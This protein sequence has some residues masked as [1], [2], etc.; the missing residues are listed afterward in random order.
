MNKA[1]CALILV[2]T[3][4]Q[5]K[6]SIGAPELNPSL[7]ESAGIC[8]EL[9]HLGKSYKYEESIEFFVGEGTKYWDYVYGRGYGRG[10]LERQSSKIQSNDVD[11][12]EAL[13][14]EQAMKLYFEQ[15]KCDGVIL[16][17]G[18]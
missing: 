15:F 2:S 16:K 9:A 6:L 10:F 4:S 3:S 8:A 1:L 12:S 18:A 14:E 17:L 11:T 5:A 13:L 7:I